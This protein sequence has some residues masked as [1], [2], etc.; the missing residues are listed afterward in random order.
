M[1]K[2]PELLYE[3]FLRFGTISGA[4]ESLHYD[5]FSNVLATLEYVEINGISFGY[6]LLGVILFFIPRSI[7]VSKPTSTGE[8]IGEY[9]MNTTPRDYSNLSNAIVS[10]GYIN[11]GI[12]GVVL[13]GNYFSIFYC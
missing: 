7:W 5:A 10:E 8:L 2:N 3:S 11:L 4:F 1:L 9:L 6:Q 13:F 12:I